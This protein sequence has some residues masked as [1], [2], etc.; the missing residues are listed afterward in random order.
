[1]VF[2]VQN[3]FHFVIGRAEWKTVGLDR[4]HRERE[5]KRNRQQDGQSMNFKQEKASRNR[6]LPLHK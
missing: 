4:R 3:H 6:S 1:L 2:G 5:D